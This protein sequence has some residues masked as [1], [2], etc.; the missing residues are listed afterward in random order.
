ML[1]IK[2]GASVRGLRAETL[3]GLMVA[4]SVF[5]KFGIDMTLT[6]GEGS[7]HG[8]G[9]LHYV[10]LAVDIR[11]FNVPDHLL[12]A[13]REAIH[14]ALGNDDAK[15]IVSEYDFVLESDHFHLE[16]QPK[17]QSR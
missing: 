4:Y 3:L 12:P 15:G 17:T 10:G 13:V 1:S 11:E 8:Y 14:K 6:E 7:T 2:P 9:S 5:D 16:F